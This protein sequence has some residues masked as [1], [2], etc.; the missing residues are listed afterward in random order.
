MHNENRLVVAIGIWKVDE[1]IARLAETEF[2][3]LIARSRQRLLEN[4]MTSPHKASMYS[5]PALHRTLRL[6]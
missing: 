4:C 6:R 3:C 5:Q 1:A 2:F